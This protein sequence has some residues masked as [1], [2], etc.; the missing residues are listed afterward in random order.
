MGQSERVRSGRDD[1][2]ESGVL[3]EL[4]LVAVAIGMIGSLIITQAYLVSDRFDEAASSPDVG[5]AEAA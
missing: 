1:R 3:G 4:L 5:A 2:G